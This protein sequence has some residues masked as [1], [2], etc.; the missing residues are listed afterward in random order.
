MKLYI[1]SFF[2]SFYNYIH[3]IYVSTD[4][5]ENLYHLFP[6]HYIR[7]AFLPYIVYIREPRNF[8]IILLGARQFQS[9]EKHCYITYTSTCF[10][11]EFFFL[12][13]FFLHRE[14]TSNKK[15]KTF[16]HL[17]SIIFNVSPVRKSIYYSAVY[18]YAYRESKLEERA[19]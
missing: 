17:F 8:K 1:P 7:A 13:F 10:S 3:S 2:S 12:F 19:H 11:K 6:P 9:E 16:H 15:K 14:S 5:R 4:E 18:I